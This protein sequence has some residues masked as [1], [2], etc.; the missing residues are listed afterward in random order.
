MKLSIIR[1]IGVI[2]LVAFTRL[3]SA[4]VTIPPEVID[5]YVDGVTSD[6]NQYMGAYMSPLLK[7][8]GYG[9]NNGWYNTARPHKSFGFDIT[10]SGNLAY[11]PA[12]D[13]NFIFVPDNY[14][15]LDLA[16]PTNNVLPT[17]AGGTTD[18]EIRSYLEKGNPISPYVQTPVLDGVKN[19]LPTKS[20]AIPSPI[21]QIGVGLYKGTEV[22]VRW[23]PTIQNDAGIDYKYWGL[24]VM[25]NVSQWIPVMKDLKF[26][27]ISGFIGFTKIAL[28]YNLDPGDPFDGQN[29][30]ADFG[31][32]TITYEIVASATASV[33]TGY[34]GLGFDNF[35]TNL[36][37]DGQY[38]VR[39]PGTDV[40]SGETIQPINNPVALNTKDGGFRA[41]IGARLK[42]AILTLH[43]SYTLQGYNTLN[44]GIGFSF[45]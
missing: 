33:I 27:N 36:N 16:D 39:I 9:F 7:G 22:K 5:D 34:V 41:T 38:D 2:F 32:N 29:Q 15:V 21:I 17:V 44:A 43:A 35:K 12:A 4:Q 1:T 13:E 30:K 18:V 40:G 28:V 37:M 42:L 19:D 8:L 25:H 26:L 6:F 14:E 3:A 24:G 45:R 31:V 20:V 10:I 23:V 11:V